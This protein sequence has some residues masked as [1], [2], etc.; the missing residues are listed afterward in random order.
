MAQN[1]KMAENCEWLKKELTHL[2][3]EYTVEPEPLDNQGPSVMGWLS[4]PH[5]PDSVVNPGSFTKYPDLRPDQ[6]EDAHEF[7]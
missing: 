1:R 3:H 2:P 7:L 6:Q 4:Q 5:S